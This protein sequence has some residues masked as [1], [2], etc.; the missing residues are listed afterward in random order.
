MAIRGCILDAGGTL[1]ESHDAHAQSW[2]IARG[3]TGIDAPWD[4]AVHA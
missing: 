4:G 2:R 1:V 3:E